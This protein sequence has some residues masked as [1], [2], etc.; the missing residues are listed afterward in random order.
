MTLLVKRQKND[1]ADAKTICEAASRPTMRFVAVKNE[2]QQAR[3]ILFRT[4][5]LLVRQRTQAI[6]ALHGYLVEYGVIAPQGC[7]HLARLSVAVR[8]PDS[9][10]SE[11]VRELGGVLLEQ[12]ASLKEKIQELEKRLRASARED[13]E[14]GRL[15]SI[16]GVGPIC[17]SAIQAFAPPMASFRRGRDFSAWLGIVPPQH[18]TEGKPR[19][20][21]ISKMG[22]RDLRRLL[23]TGAMSVAR[24]A[25]RRGAPPGSWLARMLARKPRMLVAVALAN[26]MAR[27]AWALMTKK[28]VYKEPPP[29]A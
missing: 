28:E 4:R 20:G 10:L 25:V 17:A 26:R 12:I 2:E 16:P 23:I 8:V 1:Q 5:D 13:K 21:K 27:I 7:A 22:Q 6:N 11:A 18:S 29:V 19:L 9:G 14:T 15:M 24:W 3:G